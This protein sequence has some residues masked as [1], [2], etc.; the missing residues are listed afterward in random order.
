M[1]KQTDFILKKNILSNFTKHRQCESPKKSDQFIMASFKVY[2]LK[3]N[4]Q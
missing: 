2:V 4:L 3:L 1:F